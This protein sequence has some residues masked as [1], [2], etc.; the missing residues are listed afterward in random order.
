MSKA[1]KTVPATRNKGKDL[2][3]TIHDLTGELIDAVQ[4]LNA[5]V[6]A[7]D[8]VCALGSV[9]NGR[10]LVLVKSL[11][12]TAANTAHQASTLADELKDA[13]RGVSRG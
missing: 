11:I 3:L 9:L 7:T 12:S 1:T 6:T 5:I 2:E 8:E 13:R 10:G 4:R